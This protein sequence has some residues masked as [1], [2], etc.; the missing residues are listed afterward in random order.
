MYRID[1]FLNGNVYPIYSAVKPALRVT[2]ATY[3]RE[4]NT[5]G[6]LTFTI[7]NNHPNYQALKE[8]RGH[9]KLYYKG[10]LLF[11]ARIFNIRYNI[12]NQK[13]VECEGI[14]SYLCDNVVRPYQFDEAH[15]IF[16]EYESNTN[17]VRNFIKDIVNEHNS[18]SLVYEHQFD[19]E[20]K[21]DGEITDE[22]LSTSQT[23][24]SNAWAE[25]TGKVINNLG[26]YIDIE[27]V[28]DYDERQILIYKDKMD[29]ISK[30]EIKYAVNLLEFTIETDT[31]NFAT[32]IYPVSNYTSSDG[33]KHSIVISSVNSGSPFLYDY[34]AIEQYGSLNKIVVFEGIAQPSTLKKTAQRKLAEMAN[35]V[36]SVVAT[37]IDMSVLSSDYMPMKVGENV[38]IKSTRHGIDTT[39]L[40]SAFDVNILDPE[41]SSYTFN[42]TIKSYVGRRIKTER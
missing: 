23:S 31:S 22:Y 6:T 41:S 1:Y 26:G 9:I 8:F 4:L 18:Q 24:F 17:T 35:P 39:A 3:H 28:D 36:S 16:T 13:T 19:F 2:E 20:D 37:A 38:N 42:S 27:Y 34:D 29:E 25:I 30:Q 5:V 32:G 14:L 15:R 11:I 21:S 12:Y 10:K 40:L 7:L 33:T